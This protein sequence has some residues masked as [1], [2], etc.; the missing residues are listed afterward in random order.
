MLLSFSSCTDLI[1]T[2]K[3]QVVT[4]MRI[5]PVQ[6]QL[7]PTVVLVLVAMNSFA[8]LP[9]VFV[10]VTEEVGIHFK[11]TNG[12]IDRWHV[13]E[14]MGS[15]AVFFDYDNDDQLDLYVVNSGYVSE[16][17]AWK[18]VISQRWEWW[19]YRCHHRFRDRRYQIWDGSGNR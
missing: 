16:T 6:S 2:W 15:G 9:P 17:F 18:Y 12:K 1:Y 11:H 4:Y 19:L 14:T 10:D 7:L 3:L 13:I 5:T 8:D